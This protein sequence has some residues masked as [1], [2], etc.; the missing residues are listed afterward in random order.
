MIGKTGTAQ[1]AKAST[2]V[3]AVPQLAGAAMVFR[4]DFP[5]GG[6]CFG[7]PGDVHACDSGGN[8][9]GARTPALTWF[10]AMSKIMEGEPELPLPKADREY[11]R[12]KN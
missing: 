6:L 1:E 10:S 4:P 7:G 12:M 3:G 8:M 9:Q 5:E 11:A 2:F